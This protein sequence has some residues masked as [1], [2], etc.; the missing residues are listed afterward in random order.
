MVFK[1]KNT[2]TLKTCRQ[3]LAK[4]AMSCVIDGYNLLHAL[5]LDHEQLTYPHEGRPDSLTDAG[6]TKARVIHDLLA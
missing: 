5:G 1:P 2:G 4:I 6:V 3:R